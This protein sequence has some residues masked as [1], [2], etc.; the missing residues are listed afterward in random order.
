MGSP[1]SLLA[2]WIAVLLVCALSYA[3]YPGPE[4]KRTL[5][6]EDFWGSNGSLPDNASWIL[7]TGTSYP[8]GPA[9]W[10]TGE[11]ETYSNKPRFVHQNGDGHLSITPQLINGQWTSARIET[12]QMDFEAPKNGKLRVEASLSAPSV[13]SFNG[14]GYW[15]AFWVLGSGVRTG[16]RTRPAGGEFDI[17][18]LVNGDSPNGHGM[19]CVGAHW[20]KAQ[21]TK[22]G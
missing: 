12:Q 22:R 5:F 13:S 18:E 11:V 14:L 20:R 19:H 1:V 16:R 3:P 7:D 9:Q 2:I 6:L 15:P 8:G 17:M 4:W 10:G 21:R